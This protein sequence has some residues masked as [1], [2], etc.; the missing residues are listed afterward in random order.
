MLQADCG[1]VL[2]IA[3]SLDA[4]LELGQAL[5]R[6]PIGEAFAPDPSESDLDGADEAYGR[7]A[8]LAWLRL[9]GDTTVHAVI[10][11]WVTTGR[12]LQPALRGDDLAALGVPRGP[13][14]AEAL[15]TLRAGRLDGKLDDRDAEAAYVREWLSTR[16]EG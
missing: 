2:G 16:E 5:L 4:R 13:A 8:E 1:E 10:D 9:G 15:S 6:S 3:A 7:A 12:R 11:W 14:M